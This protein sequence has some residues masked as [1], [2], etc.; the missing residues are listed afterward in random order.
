MGVPDREEYIIKH[1]LSRMA[2]LIYLVLPPPQ[3]LAWQLPTKGLL[4]SR[5]S[6]SSTFSTPN[7]QPGFWLSAFPCSLSSVCSG[8]SQGLQVEVEMSTS[9]WKFPKHI[10]R[11]PM[12]SA[13]ILTGW[14]WRKKKRDPNH[15]FANIQVFSVIWGNCVSDI[16]MQNS[17]KAAEKPCSFCESVHSA[18]SVFSSNRGSNFCK[19]QFCCLVSGTVI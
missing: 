2:Q 16:L 5:T 14:F 1:P 3:S 10:D 7:P 8:S 15:S 11:E 18:C 19:T 9:R 13:V 12:G 6:L 4:D 17:H